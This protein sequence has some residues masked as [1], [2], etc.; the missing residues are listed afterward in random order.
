MQAPTSYGDF[1]G[2]G[3]RRFADTRLIVFTGVSGS[4]KSTAIEFLLDHH[5]D[6]VGVDY[7]LVAM[8]PLSFRDTYDATLIAVD[9]I[10][11][12]RHL[13][14]LARLLLAGHRLIVASH[15]PDV[16]VK[17]LLAAWRGAYFRTDDDP[18]KVA[19][20]LEQL[21]VQA[22]EEAVQRFCETYGATFT[23]VDIILEQFGGS[24]FDRSLRR[25]ER[26]CT[27]KVVP[28]D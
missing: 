12:W 8:K 20:Y 18:T 25:F 10:T 13:V 3:E 4:G 27:L 7:E 9:E 26:Y 22:S 15:L 1:L 28:G 2:L 16:A 21:G 24:D 11:E 17:C 14:D 5:P 19:A 6:F 23:D